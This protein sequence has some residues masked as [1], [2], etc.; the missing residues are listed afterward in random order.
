MHVPQNVTRLVKTTG[1]RQCTGHGTQSRKMPGPSAQR[2]IESGNG[3]IEIANL[4]FERRNEL[5]QTTILWSI[6]GCKTRQGQQ[7]LATIMALSDRKQ[8][9]EGMRPYARTG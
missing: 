3:G 9:F 8:G 1:L 7:C 5:D 6:A 2:F 4:H